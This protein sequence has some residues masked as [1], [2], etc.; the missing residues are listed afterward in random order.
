M[1]RIIS[2]L[3]AAVVTFAFGA[4]LAYADENTP[5]FS[6][7]NNLG[8]LLYNETHQQHKAEVGEAGARGEAPGGIREDASKEKKA[9]KKTEK[10]TW[11]SPFNVDLDRF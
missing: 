7:N 6:D 1:K 10:K 2:I 11:E 4:A 8:I 9:E 5:M 3:T